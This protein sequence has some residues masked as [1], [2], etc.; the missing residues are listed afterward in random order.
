MSDGPAREGIDGFVADLADLGITARREADVVAFEI[1][2]VD[3]SRAGQAV[4]TAVSNS[5]LG[6]WPAIPPHWVHFPTEVVITPTNSD[7]AECLPGWQ[8]HSRDLQ[9]WSLSVHP[10]QAWAAHVR[11]VL[12]NAA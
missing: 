4:S 8:R 7:Q 9:A 11:S 5:E 6:P 12:S 1:V 2:P 10:G 3:G